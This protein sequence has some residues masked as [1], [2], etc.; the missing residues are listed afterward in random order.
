MEDVAYRCAVRC[1]Q[2]CA[3]LQSERRVIVFVSLDP[4]KSRPCLFASRPVRGSRDCAAVPSATC[5]PRE[6]TCPLWRAMTLPP[7]GSPCCRATDGSEKQ[8]GACAPAEC[9]AIGRRSPLPAKAA[10]LRIAPESSAARDSAYLKA[11]AWSLLSEHLAPVS[12]GPFLLTG[13]R[14]KIGCGGRSHDHAHPAPHEGRLH[15]NWSRHRSD[16]V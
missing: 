12:P 3:P 11:G 16:Q 14:Q 7:A 4:P 15:R 8:D 13:V 10:L 2:R 1:A 9:L 5:Q 6:G